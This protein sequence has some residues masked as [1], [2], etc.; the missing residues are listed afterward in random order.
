[1]GDTID[2]AFN[3]TKMI[4]SSTKNNSK[5]LTLSGKYFITAI[6]YIYKINN[7]DMVME[8]VKDTRDSK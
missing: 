8:V 4:D 1:M 7:F 2:L 5:D 6:R 3:Q